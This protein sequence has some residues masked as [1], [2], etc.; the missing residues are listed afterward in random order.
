MASTDLRGTTGRRASGM[1]LPTSRSIRT[2][3]VLG[4]ALAFVL[5]ACS[6]T[7]P[8]ARTAQTTAST[9][10]ARSAGPSV[11]RALVLSGG[12]PTGRAFEL[13]ILKGLHDAGVDL[14]QADLIVG[15]SAGAVL[16]SQV[17]AGK[18]LDTMYSALPVPGN[19][20]TAS[21]DPGYDPAYFL[22]TLQIIN[23]ATQVTPALR[24]EVG[25]R[26][27]AATKVLSETDRLRFIDEDLG[28]L[29]HEWPRQPL[30]LA[31]GDVVDGTM[32]FFDSTQ[33]VPIESALEATTALPGRVAPVPIGDRRYMDGFVGGPCPGGC[34]P[35]LDGAAGYGVIVVVMTGQG[36]AVTQQVERMRSQGSQIVVIFPDTEPEAARGQNPFDRSALKPTAEAALRQAATVAGE[37]RNVWGEPLSSIAH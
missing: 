4:T 24:I 2:L 14:A 13:G 18:S 23:G 8:A 1:V 11:W 27:L 19:V 15:T 3:A 17:R 34:W 33:S 31:A 37:V 6:G 29:I 12:G 7:T 35:N 28:G 32:R 25:K 30:K 20:P 22:Q 16:G 36:P 26:A 10:A 21:G 9:A 5:S